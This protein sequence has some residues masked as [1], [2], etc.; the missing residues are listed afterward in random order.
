MNIK[1]TSKNGTTLKTA[2][3]YCT[4]DINITFDPNI[5]EVTT[6]EKTFTPTST[7]QT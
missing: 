6:E 5:L 1:I 7:V 4:E 3:K 2:S